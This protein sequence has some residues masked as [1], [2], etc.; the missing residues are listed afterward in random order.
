MD[1]ADIQD[2]MLKMLE[3]PGDLTTF[4]KVLKMIY[5]NPANQDPIDE[6]DGP[7]VKIEFDEDSQKKIFVI[8][9]RFLTKFL[10]EDLINISTFLATVNTFKGAP[11][12]VFFTKS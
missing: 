6:E 8:V 5:E 11:Y 10:E 9:N 3:Q 2:L 7:R 1:S 4:I 12:E